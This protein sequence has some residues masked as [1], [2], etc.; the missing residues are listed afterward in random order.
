[1]PGLLIIPKIKKNKKKEAIAKQHLMIQ[2]KKAVINPAG[3]TKD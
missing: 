2:V 3:T 1:M